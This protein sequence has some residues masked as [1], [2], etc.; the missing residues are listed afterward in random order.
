[1]N[2]DASE[3]HVLRNTWY[4]IIISNICR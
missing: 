1:M 4:V 3:E 2:A